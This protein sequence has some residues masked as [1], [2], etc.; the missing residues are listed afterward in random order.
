MQINATSVDN[1]LWI[2]HG[3]AKDS[4]GR[5][6]ASYDTLIPNGN[7]E[8]YEIDV[9]TGICTPITD[10]P[11]QACTGIAFGPGDVLYAINDPTAGSSGAFF[12]LHTIDPLT[13]GTTLIGSTGFQ[14]L[15]NLAYAQGKLWAFGG[16]G[17]GLLT[18]DPVTGL[19]TDVNP[20]FRG[21]LDFME[22]IAFGDDGVLYQVDAGF[23]IQDTVT[24]VPCF[25]GPLNFPGVLGGIEYLPGP[26]APF[27]LG[28]QGKTGGPMSVQVTGATALGQVAFL[29][30][31]GG[32]GPSFVPG[33]NPCA[34]TLLDLNA[35]RSLIG[36]VRADAAGRAALGPAFVP[37][38]AAPAT[39]LQA[40]DVTSCVPTNP[41]R[42]IY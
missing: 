29:R 40:L 38:A 37:L 23:W 31:Q 7:S 34:G 19:G 16:S 12:D 18:I 5:I 6:V 15:G 11:L 28:T 25:V 32:G 24:G 22:S 42:L 35:S 8:L 33:G 41:A 14:N 9:G 3:L 39:R 21:P 17:A 1:H 13:G 4:T 30:A 20:G 10:F 26:A 36:L 27:T 2:W